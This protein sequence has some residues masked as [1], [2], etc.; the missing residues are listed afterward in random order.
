M[1]VCVVGVGALGRHHARILNQIP[2]VD[3]VAVADPQAEQGQQVAET[4]GCEW[5]PD[6]RTLLDRVDAA[7]IVV[8]TSLHLRVGSDFLNHGVPV[9]IEKPLAGNVRDGKAL[10]DL[11][12]SKRLPLQVGHIERFNPAFQELQARC[13]EPKYI[14]AERMSPYPFRSTDI[15]VVHDLMIHD[16][17]LIVNLVGEQPCRVEAFGVSVVG[18]HEDCVQARLHFPGGCIADV[19]AHRVCP[20]A[21]RSL[22]VWSDQGCVTADLQSRQ[23]VGFTPR[24][25]VRAGQL[26]F[27]LSQQPGADIPTLKADMFGHFI[28]MEEVA[29]SSADALTAELSSFL[30]AVREHETPKVDGR[31]ALRALEV[32]E[33]VLTS[34]KAHQWDGS[35]TGRTGPMALLDMHLPKTVSHRR[36]A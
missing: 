12:L 4:C 21:R 28:A 27:N 5:T 16:L 18:G 14:R 17:E 3:L 25:P 32:A 15:G 26:P 20:T 35:P 30:D 23:V 11:A 8:P 29:G 13:G 1:R 34:V 10:V 33:Q 36:A 22:Q 19:T 31:Q 9:L 6:Y 2:G 24:I 7:S